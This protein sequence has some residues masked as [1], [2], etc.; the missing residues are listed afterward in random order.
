MPG[1]LWISAD[2]LIAV[3]RLDADDDRWTPAEDV[4]STPVRAT[5]LTYRRDVR[6]EMLFLLAKR[7]EVPVAHAVPADELG[8]VVFRRTY[9]RGFAKVD[10]VKTSWVDVGPARFFEIAWEL[11][12][13]QAGP[14]R[15]IERIA[16]DGGTVHVVSAE[17]TPRDLDRHRA[18]ALRWLDDA[19]FEGLGVSPGSA[20]RPTSLDATR[21]EL[22]SLLDRVDALRSRGLD[23]DALELATAVHVRAHL[24][25]GEEDALTLRAV[26]G[27]GSALAALGRREAARDLLR[28]ALD[29]AGALPDDHPE[30]VA[31]GVALGETLTE[32]GALDEAEAVLTRAFDRADVPAA[33]GPVEAARGHLYLR[34]GQRAPA[35][36][37]L[38]SAL[39]ILRA[40]LAERLAVDASAAP[41]PAL[42]RVLGD[43]GR[44]AGERGQLEAAEPYLTAALDGLRESFGD[45]HP[46][47]ARGFVSLGTL[48]LRAKEPKLADPVLRK[49]LDAARKAFG[50]SHPAVADRLVDVA[51]NCNALGAAAVIEPLLAEALT[52]RTGALG[53][54]H[55]DTVW[56]EG[57]LT[58]IRAALAARG[59]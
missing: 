15:K 40:Q 13:A 38:Q 56:V 57:Q 45:A 16:V 31:L 49:A 6:D 51:M 28:G 22:D 41:P 30:V 34:R 19:R 39:T 17:G 42:W 20:A 3:P 1:L 23:G 24:E 55:P 50:P 18:I 58:G 59:R 54:A 8:Q 29:R 25:R 10:I 4:S 9:E 11:W 7:Y 12:H 44:L 35:E 46:E 48:Y 52:I 33:R 32:L 26:R 47:T 5:A 27:R 21:D 53:P 37:S 2:A 43:L 36:A 14:V